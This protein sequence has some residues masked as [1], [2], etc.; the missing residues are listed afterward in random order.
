MLQNIMLNYCVV[1]DKI[2]NLSCLK[3]IGKGLWIVLQ[4]LEKLVY[5]VFNIILRT[6]Q[7]NFLK[8]FRNI[9]ICFYNSKNRFKISKTFGNNRWIF[10][11]WSYINWVIVLFFN[12]LSWNWITHLYKEKKLQFMRFLK[13]SEI[14]FKIIWRASQH[15]SKL[16]F[17]TSF[18]D[19][20]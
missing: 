12:L 16:L 5:K 17:L 9:H 7:D 18:Q 4:K 8:S 1:Q 3:T 19:L 15:I 20:A 10:G 13:F 2:F 14:F 6:L 11:M